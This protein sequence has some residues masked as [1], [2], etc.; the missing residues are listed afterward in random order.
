M[1]K[2]NLTIQVVEE[3]LEE[4]E[5]RVR[6]ELQGMGDGPHKSEIRQMI[7]TRQGRLMELKDIRVQILN[8]TG[9][10]LKGTRAPKDVRGE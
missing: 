10:E 4:H 5:H 6:A 2:R 3:I 9:V 1:T 8:E 7:A